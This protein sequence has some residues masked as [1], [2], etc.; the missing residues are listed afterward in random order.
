MTARRRTTT[1]IVVAL[2]VAGTL[3]CTGDDPGTPTGSEQTTPAETADTTREVELYFPGS[4]GQLHAES[5]TLPV[6]DKPEDSVRGLLEALLLGPQTDNLWRPLSLA[7]TVDDDLIAAADPA[8]TVSG[9]TVSGG[10]VSGDEIA[11]QP[12]VITPV[13]PEPPPIGTVRLGP[14]Y[15]LTGGTVVIDFEAQSPPAVGSREEQLILFSLVNTV[16][17]NTEQAERL[18]ILWNGSQPHTFAGHLDTGT[19]LTP[20]R[21]LIGEPAS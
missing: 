19:A 17:L 15:L 8:G 2:V 4:D 12:A 7:P 5:R 16:L 14:V 13:R 9:G 10:T 21:S 6:E 1:R 11:A 18:L 20:N 3:A